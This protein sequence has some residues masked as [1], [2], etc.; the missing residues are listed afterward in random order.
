MKPYRWILLSLTGALLAALPITAAPE[1]EALA[2]SDRVDELERKVDLLTDELARTRQEMG[3][4]EEK[5]E[6]ESVWGLGPAASKVYGLSRGLSIGGYAEAFGTAIVHDKKDTTERNR[7]D[8]LRAVLYAG[9]KFTDHIVFNSEIE[10]EHGTTNATESSGGGS[11]SVEFAALD[12]LLRDELNVRGGLLLIPM[13]FINEMHEP[14]FFYGVN[15]P[16]VE[17]AIIPTTWRHGGAGLFGRV[18]DV[19]EYKLYAV[20]SF[21]AAGFDDSGLRGGRQQGNRELAEDIAFVGRVDIEPIP[22]LLVGGSVFVGETGQDQEVV[23]ADG[24]L[25]DFPQS[26]LILWEAHSEL[27][28]MG[29]RGR[30]LFTMAHVDDAG[31]LTLALR[32]S[33]VGSS[34][35]AAGEAVASDMLGAYGE[36]GYD[37]MQWIAPDSGWTVEPFFRYEYVDTQHAMPRGFSEDKTNVLYI[38]TAGVSVKPIPNVVVKLDYRNRDAREGQVAD[39]VNLGFGLVF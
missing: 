10:F 38:Y 7:F 35:I 29:F 39:E 34:E 32:P 8:A 24:V 28:A 25:I 19:I 11:V 12:F 3:V 9:Y 15:R 36:V 6:L 20:T 21:N 5:Q 17:Q 4:P 27:N 23:N 18:A 2:E 22:A 33:P 14:P 13:G 1:D 31:E 16:V 30:V 26:R 37:V